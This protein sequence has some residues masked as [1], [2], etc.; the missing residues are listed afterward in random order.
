M[1]ISGHGI[2]GPRETTVRVRT[3]GRPGSV[4]F[5]AAAIFAPNCCAAASAAGPYE[6][7][8]RI[9]RMPRI[10]DAGVAIGDDRLQAVA[11]LGAVLFILDREEQQDAFVVRLLADAPLVI[12][13]VGTSSVTSSPSSESTVT[14]AICAPVARSRIP[15]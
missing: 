11:D 10:I 12:E 1:T 3:R 13:L 9:G 6:P 4:T 2:D 5:F 14:I 8:R 15:Q 7:C